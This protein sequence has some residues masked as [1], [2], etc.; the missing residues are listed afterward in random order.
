M[1]DTD[2]VAAFVSE[3]TWRFAKTMPLW[4]HWYVMEQWNPD[5]EAEFAELVRRI[6]EEGRDEEWGS[7]T[8][9][10]TVRYYYLDGYKYWAMDPTIDETDLV[11]RARLDGKGPADGFTS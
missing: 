6:F 3:V 2:P 11:N 4:P 5:R 10:R 8:Y 9:R 1:S 7:G